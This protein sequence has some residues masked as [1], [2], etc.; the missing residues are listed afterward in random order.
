MFRVSPVNFSSMVADAL[1]ALKLQPILVG[2]I[3]AQLTLVFPFFSLHFLYFFIS[4]FS[5]ACNSMV[6]WLKKQI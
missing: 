1:L 3:L 6:F 5:I 2:T 4:N